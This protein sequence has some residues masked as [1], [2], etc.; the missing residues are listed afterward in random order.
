ME[1]DRLERVEGGHL[2]EG[3]ADRD[4]TRAAIGLGD[5]NQPARQKEGFD[6]VVKSTVSDAGHNAGEALQRVRVVQE[7]QAVVARQR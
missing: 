1:R 6:A 3:L 7:G 4:R 2:V 5:S